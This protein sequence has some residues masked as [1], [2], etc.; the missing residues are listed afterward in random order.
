MD[1]H[2]YVRKMCILLFVGKFYLRLCG[3]VRGCDIFIHVSSTFWTFIT[4]FS[5]RCRITIVLCI[6]VKE[7]TPIYYKIVDRYISSIL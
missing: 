1:Y 2:L 4:K 6:L 3:I 5:I 7:T